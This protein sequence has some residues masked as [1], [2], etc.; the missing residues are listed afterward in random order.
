MDS[1]KHTLSNNMFSNNILAN[2]T[3]NT[4]NNL[5]NFQTN[6]A[7]QQPTNIQKDNAFQSNIFTENKYSTP[8]SAS[9]SVGLKRIESS[10]H[11]LDSLEESYLTSV[12]E[13]DFRCPR[14][15]PFWIK[16]SL[17]FKCL[18]RPPKNQLFPRWTFCSSPHYYNHSK[19]RR[20]SG[21][22]F[23]SC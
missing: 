16:L 11:A 17:Q 14:P 6:G 21:L 22:R 5:N 4:C 8:Q 7:L 20:P 2:N 15:L 10:R 13:S 18:W 9:N 12:S 23:Q 1:S 19:K 3:F